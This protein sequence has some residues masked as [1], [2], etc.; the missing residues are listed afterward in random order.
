MKITGNNNFLK[1][2]KKKPKKKKNWKNKKKKKK[3]LLQILKRTRYTRTEKSQ[4]TKIK[5][6][7]NVFTKKYIVWELMNWNINCKN[8]QKGSEGQKYEK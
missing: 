4:I 1:S 5:I 7:K 3:N 6:L 2:K 8:D